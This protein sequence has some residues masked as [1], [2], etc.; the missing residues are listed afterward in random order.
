MC[1]RPG[2]FK[3]GA[4]LLLPA[5]GST[6]DCKAARCL[7]H[8]HEKPGR[9]RGVPRVTHDRA[10][11]SVFDSGSVCARHP[12]ISPCVPMSTIGPISPVR[13][14]RRGGDTVRP[15]ASGWVSLPCHGVGT[16]HP[17]RAPPPSPLLSHPPHAR[18]SALHRRFSA[19]GETARVT[20]ESF[21]WFP[22]HRSDVRQCL[23]HPAA[24]CWST[25]HSP[26]SHRTDQTTVA[27]I[28]W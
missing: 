2:K 20:A 9:H 17:D 22:D 8:L 6:P 4:S 19:A 14:G 26:G 28:L 25:S 5:L 7:R 15:R 10:L 12:R 21:L 18:Q 11:R 13:L 3:S 16:P 27:S 1:W 23:R 24:W